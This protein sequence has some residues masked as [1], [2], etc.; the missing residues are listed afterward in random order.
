MDD[1]SVYALKER[2]A[3]GTLSFHETT[4]GAIAAAEEKAQLAV[5]DC[6][7]DPCE[8]RG[9]LQLTG[10]TLTL[11]NGFLDVCFHALYSDRGDEVFEYTIIRHDLKK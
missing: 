1:R 10:K 2:G 4:D 8:S 6:N 11:G 7:T 9:E 3:D 5:N